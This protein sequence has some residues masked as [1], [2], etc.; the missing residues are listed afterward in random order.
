MHGCADKIIELFTVKGANSVDGHFAV[1]SSLVSNPAKLCY[2][3]R[4]A[5]REAAVGEWPS[6]SSGYSQVSFLQ[7]N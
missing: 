4:Q 5:L 1:D 3:V 6:Q 2:V 7:A